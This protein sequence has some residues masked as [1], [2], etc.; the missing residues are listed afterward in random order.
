[1][2]KID[3]SFLRIGNKLTG[4]RLRFIGAI[5]SFYVKFQL[6]KIPRDELYFVRFAESLPRHNAKTYKDFLEFHLCIR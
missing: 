5:K 2:L 4:F 3:F 6:E 1:M